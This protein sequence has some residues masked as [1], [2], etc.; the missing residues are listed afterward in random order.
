MKKLIYI[1]LVLT[2]VFVAS[3]EI[4]FACSCMITDE[5]LETQIQKA[6]DGST[7]VF[8]GEV[9]SVEPKDEYTLSVKIKTLQIWK[10]EETDEF[11]VN[12]ANQSAMCGYFF[13]VGKKYLVY[14]NKSGEVLMATNCSRTAIFDEAGDAKRLDK[15]TETLKASANKIRLKNGVAVNSTIGGEAHD[16]Y[17]IRVRKGQTLHIQT[18]WNGNRDRNVSFFVTRSADFF[19]SEKVERGIETYDGKNWRLKMARTGD[20]YIYVTAYPTAEYTVKATVK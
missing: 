9:V 19:K 6:F 15:L 12:T 8:S 2:I 13:E 3:A 5:P 7:S 14:A 16:S 10:G 17:V 1:S 4:T 11:T 20:Y 18:S